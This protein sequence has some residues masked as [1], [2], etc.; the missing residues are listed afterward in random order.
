[1]ITAFAGFLT[2]YIVG[3]RAGREG[4]EELVESWE[5][6]RSSDEFQAIMGAAGGLMGS[7]FEKTGR[8]PSGPEMVDSLSSAAGAVMEF[9]QKRSDLRVVS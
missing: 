3:A 2:G 9:L 1:M 7:F 5:V 6:I 4:F 8:T